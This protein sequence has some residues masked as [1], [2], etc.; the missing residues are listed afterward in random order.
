MESITRRIKQLRNATLTRI[1]KEFDIYYRDKYPSYR[2]VKK[3]FSWP[4]FLITGFWLIAK[5]MYFFAIIYSVIMLPI[6]M[7][8]A[9]SFSEE[10]IVVAATL[11]LTI[12]IFSLFYFGFW[13][14]RTWAWHLRQKGYRKILSVTSTSPN[15]AINHY[16][17]SKS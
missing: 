16:L 17:D 14:N 5:R 7:A 13:G 6:N 8:S 1:M 12:L 4:G 3:G 9:S 2:A 10:I 11:Y 15:N